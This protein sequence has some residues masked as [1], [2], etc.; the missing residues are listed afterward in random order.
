MI[1]Q[2]AGATAFED[3]EACLMCHKYPRMGR[4]TQEGV[5]RSY[6]VTPKMFAKTVHRNVPCRDCHD[7]IKEL[8]HRP[9]KE[10]VRCD[11][12]CHSKNNPATGKPFSHRPIYDLY[13]K[14]VHAREKR[15]TG[16]GT[17]KPYCI[18]C[19]TNPVYNPHEEVPPKKILDR[20]ELC[21][22]KA[23]FVRQWYFHTS[24]RVLEVKR[25]GQ[26]LVDLCTRCH[27]NE[28]LID[29]HLEAAEDEG[30]QLGEKFPIA[31]V[32][33]E[34]SFH[35]KV[36]RY[37]FH[38]AAT[39]LDCHADNSEYYEGVHEILASRDPAS[40]VSDQNRVATCKRCHES[41]DAK[42]VDVDPHP[43][44]DEEFNPILHHAESI[45][46]LVSEIIV[47]ALLGLSMFE[48][49]GRRRDGAGW[50]LRWGSTW[51]RR[52][53]RKRARIIPR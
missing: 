30:R 2:A 44:F 43:S 18:T 51:W 19:H 7:Y 14:S 22:E 33:Y 16:T 28:D 1:W 12:Q 50:R 36:S 53:K 37:G 48:T 5:F 47:V 45:Y 20:C 10:G 21:H 25:S 31:A 13:I 15:A 35:G 38:G 39:C 27:S 46:G 3:D 17:D 52:S 4:V 24:R 42:Y 6:H 32:S 11:Q 23:N 26:E 29:R 40:P 9:V 41:A 49:V 34:K 8:P